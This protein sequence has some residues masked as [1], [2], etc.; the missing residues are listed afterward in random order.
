M[1]AKEIKFKTFNISFKSSYLTGTFSV[2]YNTY[3]YI[4]IRWGTLSQ[5]RQRDYTRRTATNLSAKRNGNIASRLFVA[6]I[7]G[8]RPL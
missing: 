5:R 1:Y 7:Y 8:D 2:L 3:R 4:G 6:L